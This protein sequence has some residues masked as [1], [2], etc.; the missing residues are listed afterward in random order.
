MLKVRFWSGLA[1]RAFG[2]AAAIDHSVK[3]GRAWTTGLNKLRPLKDKR[4]KGM[5]EKLQRL[6]PAWI[7]AP[8]CR[9][10][11]ITLSACSVSWARVSLAPF[12]VC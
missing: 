6:R 4:Q 10:S 7:G 11:C 5:E 12:G 2:P 8:L 1:E 3:P 9:P